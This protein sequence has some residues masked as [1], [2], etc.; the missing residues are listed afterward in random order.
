MDLNTE[1]SK[2]IW[3]WGSFLKP[4]LKLSN[5]SSEFQFPVMF[6]SNKGPCKTL[7]KMKPPPSQFVVWSH[8]AA[9][10]TLFSLE[11]V[12]STAGLHKT[13]LTPA[14]VQATWTCCQGWISMW[15]A[16]RG[17]TLKEST[18]S[19]TQ[20]HCCSL[21]ARMIHSS[22]HIWS[23]CCRWDQEIHRNRSQICQKSLFDWLWLPLIYPHMHFDY[24]S[25]KTEVK[26]S[27]SNNFLTEES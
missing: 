21:R 14:A 15:S 9:L 19:D 26:S 25:V 10:H 2:E 1:A 27:D 24:F 18:W 11:A 3:Q 8:S 16:L 4:N 23:H 7:I 12:K 6:L 20:P 17:E 22:P 5:G 13:I